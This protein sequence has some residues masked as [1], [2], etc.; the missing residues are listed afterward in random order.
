MIEADDEIDLA[1]NEY[2]CELAGALQLP[3]SALTGLSVD[4]EI[5]EVK[6]SFDRIRSGP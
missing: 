2:L 6:A 1:E 5:E 3:K 4:V